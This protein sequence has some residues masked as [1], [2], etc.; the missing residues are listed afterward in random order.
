MAPDRERN[1]ELHKKAFQTLS[2]PSDANGE[3]PQ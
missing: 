1:L 3:V 2:S